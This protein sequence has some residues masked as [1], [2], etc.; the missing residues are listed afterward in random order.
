MQARGMKTDITVTTEERVRLA[1]LIADR[2]SPAKVVWRSRIVLATADG[3]SVKAICRATGMSKPCVWRWQKRFAEYGVDGLLRDKTRPPGRKPLA[4]ATKAKLLAKTAR[5]TPPDAT[6]WSVRTM[7]KA[8]GISRT[9]VQRI[10][11]EAGLKPHLTARF[12]VSNDPQF[13]ENA[14]SRLGA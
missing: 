13:E 4:A 11:R 1:G 9:S 3:E 8:M 6:H 10:W 5:E 12:K 2:N 7:A 14:L